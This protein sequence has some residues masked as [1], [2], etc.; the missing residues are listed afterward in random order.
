MKFS[1]MPQPVYAVM[2]I[3]PA[4]CYHFYTGKAGRE[5]LSTNMENAFPFQTIEGAERKADMFTKY[6]DGIIWCVINSDGD[7]V[8]TSEEAEYY[9]ELERGYAQDRI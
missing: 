4:G 2:A 3:T 6:G 5:Y 8:D 1:E 9:A 7:Y